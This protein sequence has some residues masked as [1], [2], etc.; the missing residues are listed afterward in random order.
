MHSA[1]VAIMIALNPG[2][3][4]TGLAVFESIRTGK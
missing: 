4:I 2:F 3:L 1:I